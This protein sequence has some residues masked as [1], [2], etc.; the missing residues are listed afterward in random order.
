MNF[1]V[2]R[3]VG[4]RTCAEVEQKLATRPSVR[5]K[6]RVVKLSSRRPGSE[7]VAIYSAKYETVSTYDIL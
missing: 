2:A 4:K 5:I 7:N 3:L 6:C 1:V